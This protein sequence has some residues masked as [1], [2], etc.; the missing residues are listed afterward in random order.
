MH[1]VKKT[2]A[3]LANLITAITESFAVPSSAFSLTL[4]LP[5]HAFLP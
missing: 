4:F 2:A 5:V 3:Y 1:H